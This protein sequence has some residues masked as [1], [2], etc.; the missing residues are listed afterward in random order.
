MIEKLATHLE[1]AGW[2]VGITH[3]E[4]AKFDPPR[5]EGS[6]RIFATNGKE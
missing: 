3:R 6:S 4:A 1:A 2:R 5:A